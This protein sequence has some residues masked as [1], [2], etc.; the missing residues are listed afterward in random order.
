MHS[1]I[2]CRVH[3]TAFRC[4]GLR[5]SFIP[6]VHRELS[7]SRH[8]PANCGQGTAAPQETLQYTLA[9][10]IT[11]SRLTKITNTYREKQTAVQP[12]TN[13][14]DVC[15]IFEIIQRPLQKRIPL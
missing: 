11:E 10:R 7:S 14:H 1:E 3:E 15:S 13:A 9:R 8:A 2:H 6:A 4:S 5:L 12:V